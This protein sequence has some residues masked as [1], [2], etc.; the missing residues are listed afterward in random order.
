MLTRDYRSDV[1][2][3]MLRFDCTKTP[4]AGIDKLPGAGTAKGK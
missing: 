1:A 2:E 4:E 3:G